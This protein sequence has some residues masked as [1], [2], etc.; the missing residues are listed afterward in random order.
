MICWKK[1]VKEVSGGSSTHFQGE[2]RLNY[3]LKYLKY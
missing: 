2:N 3:G 1:D